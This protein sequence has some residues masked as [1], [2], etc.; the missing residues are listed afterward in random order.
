MPTAIFKLFRESDSALRPRLV[1]IYTL[2]GVLNLGAWAWAFLAFHGNPGLLGVALVTYGLGLQHAVD[3]DHIA[4]IDNVTRKLMQMGQRS[5]TVGLFFALS[6]SMVVIV[7]AGAVAIAATLL[8]SF[9]AMS[10]VSGVI[11][12]IVSSF[13]LLAIAAHAASPEAQ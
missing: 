7:T 6:H 10:S 4:V 5:V 13:F 2:L 3:V 11:S 1:S 8:G 12:T 9:E